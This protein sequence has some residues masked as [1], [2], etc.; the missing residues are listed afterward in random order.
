M[1][2]V[3]VNVVRKNG[4]TKTLPNQREVRLHSSGVEVVMVKGALYPISRVSPTEVNVH[5]DKGHVEAV[6]PSKIAFEA[7]KA[8]VAAVSKPR[9]EKSKRGKAK[10]K[11][12]APSINIEE[13][14]A[15]VLTA[16]GVKA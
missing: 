9:S 13:V 4:L 16:L 14:V 8:E 6:S 5:L 2:F 3:N 1:S 10:V 7:K 11:A 15:K 12:A